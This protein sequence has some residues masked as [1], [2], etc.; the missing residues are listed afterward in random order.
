MK[1]KIAVLAMGVVA[2]FLVVQEAGAVMATGPTAFAQLDWTTFELKGIDLGA[3]APT[4]TWTYQYDYSGAQVETSS[5]YDSALDWTTGTNALVTGS[6]AQA[7]TTAG[8][9]KS[10][11]SLDSDETGS[12]SSSTSRY[13]QLTVTGT[14]L[15]M[16]MVDYSWNI[17]ISEGQQEYQAANAWTMLSLYDNSYGK[18]GYGASS[19]YLP[20]STT[21]TIED[22]GKLVA[23][24]YVIDG[25][26]VN[27]QAYTGASVSA[28][29]VPAP[30]A[31]WLLGS[32]L[33]GLLAAKRRKARA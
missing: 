20:Q 5:Q 26:V 21:Y 30:A 16:A 7:Q 1:K 28:A 2:G 24:L 12:A 31:A 23:A 19:G 32:G 29:P 8:L 15:L 13:G 27:F 25:M 22:S 4:W 10:S 11:T 18:S 6:F 17:A 14:G 3:G 33:F 9:V